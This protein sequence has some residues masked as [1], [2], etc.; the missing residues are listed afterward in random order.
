MEEKEE[1]IHKHITF[2]PKKSR[3][4]NY[5][6]MQAKNGPGKMEVNKMK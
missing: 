3:K 1:Y 4:L 5:D 2:V 6:L